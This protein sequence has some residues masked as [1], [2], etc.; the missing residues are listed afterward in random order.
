MHVQRD[1]KGQ[2]ISLYVN[3][4]KLTGD[5]FFA[6]SENQELKILELGSCEFAAMD[7]V[8]LF[9]LKHVESLTLSGDSVSADVLRQLHR[10]GALKHMFLQSNRLTN[11]D[12]AIL[13]S[14]KDTL[15]SLVL[16]RSS[17]LNGDGLRHLAS[18]DKLG[19]LHINEVA[20]HL[21]S[22]TGEEL[23][24]LAELK[25]LE[26]L[27]LRNTKVSDES[28][29]H[30]ANVQSLERIALI[31]TAVSGIGFRHLTKLP[32]LIVAVL[33]AS[34]ITGDGLKEISNCPHLVN[35]S[36]N[37][38]LIT[39]LDLQHLQALSELRVVSLNKTQVSEEGLQY[40]L[41]VPKLQSAKLDDSNVPQGRIREFN[42]TLY[43]RR[44]ADTGTK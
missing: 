3:N 25:Q 41:R 7:M 10:I 28:L 11:E 1:E 38:T 9:K 23:A 36:L 8:P 32:K 17:R 27:H 22:G 26:I 37:A 44:K 20:L 18:L 35:L 33:D 5:Y 19:M 43:Q 13:A 14:L 30:L 4:A 24:S 12:L 21:P 31:E 15:T 42:E 39:D 40:L 6:I 2:V 34:P 16:S 29:K